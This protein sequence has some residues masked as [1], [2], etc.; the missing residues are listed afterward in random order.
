M[1]EFPDEPRYREDL[2][3]SH[4]WLAIWYGTDLR[5]EEAVEQR[6]I[7]LDHH[8]RSRGGVSRQRRSIA[9]ALLIN[10]H[11]LGRRL[12]GVG[13]FDEAE[14]YHRAALTD[15]GQ[16][17]P[18]CAGLEP[19]ELRLSA[20]AARPLRGSGPGDAGSPANRRSG[21]GSRARRPPHPTGQISR[22]AGAL[23]QHGRARGSLHGPLRGGRSASAP[24][25]RPSGAVVR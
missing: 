14:T 11:R 18:Y 23:P 16:L 15:D 3:E 9:N 4:G 6:R 19:R 8:A 5:L 10:N 17:E 20:A 13:R 24:G 1:Q 25:D 22:A 2:R 7:A 12:A 21:A